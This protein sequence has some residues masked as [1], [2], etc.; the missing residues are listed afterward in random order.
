[1]T[2]LSSLAA[3][4]VALADTT[5]AVQDGGDVVAR[6]G[7]KYTTDWRAPHRAVPTTDDSSVYA[8]RRASLT[9]LNKLV[10][11]MV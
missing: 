3:I 11:D 1:M 7:I 5:E 10:S 8:A 2:W 4:R 6:H 9:D